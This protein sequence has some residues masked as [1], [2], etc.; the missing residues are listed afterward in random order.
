MSTEQTAAGDTPAA[1]GKMAE[2]REYIVLRAIYPEREGEGH[3]VELGSTSARTGDE[4]EAKVVDMLPAA[5][6]GGPF[7]TVAMRNWQPTEY[8]LD[9]VPAT[10]VRRRK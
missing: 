8:T 2:A 5:E 4:A 9:E 3:W 6:Q 1:K 7:V 10:V